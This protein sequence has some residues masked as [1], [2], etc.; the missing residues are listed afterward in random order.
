[1]L[2]AWQNIGFEFAQFKNGWIIKSYDDVVA[3][4]D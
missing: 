2:K 4:V 3:L 1:M